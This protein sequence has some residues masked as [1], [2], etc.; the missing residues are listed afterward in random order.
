MYRA[1]GQSLK[2][3][4]SFPLIQGSRVG[5]VEYKIERYVRCVK[6]KLS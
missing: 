5:I 3:D 1:K 2:K 6:P 4:E